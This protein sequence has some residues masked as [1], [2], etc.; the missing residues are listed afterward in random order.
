MMQNQQCRTLQMTL[1]LMELVQKQN[2]EQQSR[3]FEEVHKARKVELASLQK[4]YET[5]KVDNL[6]EGVSHKSRFQS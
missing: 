2:L 5:M 3:N 1:L 4:K 6:S